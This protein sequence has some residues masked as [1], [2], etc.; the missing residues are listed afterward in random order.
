MSFSWGKADMFI[1]RLGEQVL[2]HLIPLRRMRDAG[3]RVA[4]STDRGPVAGRTVFEAS[5]P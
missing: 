2:E 5:T 4:C 3:M 1:E